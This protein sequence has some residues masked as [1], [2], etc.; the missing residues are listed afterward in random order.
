MSE[1]GDSRLE[2]GVIG[3]L[4]PDG[5]VA[6]RAVRP[7]GQAPPALFEERQADERAALL[8]ALG[9]PDEI[10]RAR[11][12]ALGRGYAWHAGDD[13]Q[14]RA[15][16][17]ALREALSG[18]R[19]LGSLA[20]SPLLPESAAN[21]AA[22]LADELDEPDEVLVHEGQALVGVAL[23]RAGRR[24]TVWTRDVGVAALARTHDLA[25]VDHDPLA[26]LPEALRA[27][28][29]LA[30]VDTLPADGQTAALLARANA[31]VRPEGRVVA[32]THSM[33]RAHVE[34][35]VEAAGL[36]PL[37]PL[38]EVAVRL[39][40]G[41]C[42][43][44]FV[45]DELVLRRAAEPPFAADA[46]ISPAAA[47]DLEP[48]ER[49]QGCVEVQALDPKALTPE[50]LD[51]ALDSFVNDAGLKPL[52]RAAHDDE[53]A[54]TRYLALDGGGHV[55]LTAWRDT[56]RIAVDV[57]P[58]APGLLARLCSALLFELPRAE[59]EVPLG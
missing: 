26:P 45:W 51:R 28:F 16:A 49:T 15:S 25:L 3:L 6:L 37:R 8:T 27:R 30:L 19:A 9:A 41:F 54:P 7:P 11:L 58:W 57:F 55:A 39:L 18:L 56:G 21:I 14:T 40:A 13:E 53:R 4:R 1:S 48:G 20:A 5:S 33:R 46:E 12:A 10:V 31:C 32:L 47:R 22:L 34:R 17:D 44:E 50:R 36:Q 29:A 2:A 59:E 43:A 52:H 42:P 23:A 24:V 35:V 38:H